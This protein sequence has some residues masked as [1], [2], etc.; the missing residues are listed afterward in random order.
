MVTAYNCKQYY[1]CILNC[2]Q[3]FEMSE[4]TLK[5]LELSQDLVS[6]C[7][8]LWLGLKLLNDMKCPSFEESNCL[9]RK[10]FFV[11]QFSCGF[12]IQ[13]KKYT[14]ISNEFSSF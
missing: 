5:A 10:H 3:C 2:M 11:C 14:Q 9:N 12:S 7:W 1:N 8:T 6:E 4:I 13:K